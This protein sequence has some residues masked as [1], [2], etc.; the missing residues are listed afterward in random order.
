MR[1]RRRHPILIVLGLIT[2]CILVHL[3]ALLLRVH[4]LPGVPPSMRCH[5]GVVCKRS[6]PPRL[7]ACA[8]GCACIHVCS[9]LCVH[10]SACACM[11][12]G[13]WVRV[14]MGGRS[15]GCA[16]GRAG[17]RVCGWAGRRVGR[18]AIVFVLVWVRVCGREFV[19]ERGHACAFCLALGRLWKPSGA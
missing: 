3:I 14:R 7:F 12:V 9:R 10:A 16:G 17:V 4:G 11:G 19:L 6:R 13:L 1:R 8:H 5:R 18:W 15:G 2:K